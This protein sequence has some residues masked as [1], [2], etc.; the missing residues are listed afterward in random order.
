MRGVQ[1]R[2]KARGMR[3]MQLWSV[4]GRAEQCSLLMMIEPLLL[5]TTNSDIALGSTRGAEAPD[6]LPCNS[7]DDGGSKDRGEWV[8]VAAAQL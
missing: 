5:D 8:A 1:L 3:G 4:S 2:S 7:K 6:E